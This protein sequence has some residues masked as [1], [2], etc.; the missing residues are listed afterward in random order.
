MLAA[1]VLHLDLLPCQVAMVLMLQIDQDRVIYILDV[2]FGWA[3]DVI[4]HLIYILLIFQT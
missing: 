3:Y 1:G 2:I 4:S